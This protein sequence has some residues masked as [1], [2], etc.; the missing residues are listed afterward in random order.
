M[1]V[2]NRDQIGWIDCHLCGTE[3]TVHACAVGRAGTSQ[4]LYYRCPSCGAIQPRM[5]G[6][7]EIIRRDM[8]GLDVGPKTPPADEKPARESER[9]AANDDGE[10]LPG[11]EKAAVGHDT[12]GEKPTRGFLHT[13]LYEE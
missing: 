9:P 1:A 7:Q 11:Q 2:K 3:A 13:L 8:R 10:Y 4:R 12:A 5:D 6:G